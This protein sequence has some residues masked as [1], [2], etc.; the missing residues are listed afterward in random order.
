MKYVR[1]NIKSIL[2]CFFLGISYAFVSIF[3]PNNLLEKF[4]KENLLTLVIALIAIYVPIITVILG[5]IDELKNRH[6]YFEPKK[7]IPELV[8]FIK[9]LAVYVAIIAILLITYTSEPTVL[10]INKNFSISLGFFFQA[11]LITIL[12]LNIRS[13]YDICMTLIAIYSENLE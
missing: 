10:L 8:L 7:I 2:F 9:E 6:P 3:F 1:E 13:L 12:A 5:R 4:L 11:S